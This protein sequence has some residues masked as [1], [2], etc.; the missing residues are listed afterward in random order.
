MLDALREHLVGKPELY[1][2]EMVVFL[3]GD[4]G[5]LVNPLIV[6]KALKSI[7]QSEK[8]M[9]QIARERNQDL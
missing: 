6:S 3:F 4:F 5:V 2:E 8:K 7:N 9:C 1:L